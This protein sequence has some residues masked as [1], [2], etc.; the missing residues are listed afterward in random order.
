MFELFMDPIIYIRFLTQFSP[1]L[2]SFIA[3]IDSAYNMSLK[4]ILYVFGV[5]LTLFIGKLISATFPFRVP[6]VEDGLNE[7]DFQ[8]SKIKSDKYGFDNPKYHPSCNLISKPDHAGWGTFYSSPDM[9]ALYYTFTIVY[10]INSMLNG[11]DINIFI[12]TIL[13]FLFLLSSYFRTQ[14]FYC[15]EFRD[16]LVGMVVGGFIGFLWFVFVSITQT[17]LKIYDLTYF[18]VNRENNNKC[19]MKNKQFRCKKVKM[20][21][22]K[23]NELNIIKS[24]AAE[25]ARNLYKVQNQLD[26]VDNFT[27]VWSLYRNI[28]KNINLVNNNANTSSNK[29]FYNILKDIGDSDI[30]ELITE[31]VIRKSGEY[32]FNNIYG[33]NDLN[34]DLNTNINNN[35]S[36]YYQLDDDTFR[37]IEN[38]QS[39]DIKLYQALFTNY[40]SFH[41]FITDG[42]S[43]SIADQDTKN[44]LNKIDNELTGSINL[45]NNNEREE[46]IENVKKYL[47]INILFKILTNPDD[48]FKIIEYL[49]VL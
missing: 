44:I 35:D 14:V 7:K 15:V 38:N 39:N 28:I 47:P 6:G 36:K 30:N 33:L 17:S 24:E 21:V 18:N 1:I 3:I 10:M 22:E 48:Y 34:G 32:Y 46:N 41:K 19:K 29:N 11:N 31:E 45:I 25:Q 37:L 27:A 20:N 42:I 5:S 4:G 2:F 9:Y 8:I 43:S 49:N 23:D 16:I 26:K 13:L 40:I 12:L